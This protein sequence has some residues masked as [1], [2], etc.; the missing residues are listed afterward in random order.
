VEN[1]SSLTSIRVGQSYADAK[2]N[3]KIHRVANVTDTTHQFSPHAT[4]PDEKGVPGGYRARPSGR[5][6]AFTG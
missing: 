1:A 5:L 2:G 4:K 3:L 6:S